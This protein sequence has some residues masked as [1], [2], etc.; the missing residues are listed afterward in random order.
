M[1]DSRLQTRLNVTATTT[2]SVLP[3]DLHSSFFS[4]CLLLTKQIEIK[5][6]HEIMKLLANVLTTLLATGHAMAAFNDNAPT[7]NL[8]GRQ[9][10]AKPEHMTQE[11]K[12]REMQNSVPGINEVVI[13]VTYDDFPQ[14]TGWT[15]RDS[16]GT[17]ISS[18]PT[19]SFPTAGG[20]VSRTEFVA[21]G[22]YTFEMT[23][24]FG[25]GICCSFGIGEFKITVNGE[26]IAAG[27]NGDFGDVV[28]VT[29]D[30][31]EAPTRAP[32]RAPTSAPTSAPFSAPTS[33]PTRAPT[34]AP[35]SAPSI[36]AATGNNEVVIEDTYDGFPQETGWSLRDSAGTL[37]ISQPTGS[38][39]TAGGFVSRTEFVAG[40][41]Y[42]LK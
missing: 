42:T 26:S 32:T 15:L 7:R 19:G 6:K 29:F 33:A 27:D 39:P 4:I 22:E 34:R 3:D 23:D 31:S 20:F 8:K 2:A 37:I 25:D 13:E 5:P 40:G 35:T 30:V 12:H 11:T 21:G 38:F 18:Q 14:E 24:T 36:S 9:V 1:C 10:L 41:E 28:Q 16:A 17:L